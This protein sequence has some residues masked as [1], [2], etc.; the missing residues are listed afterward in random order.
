MSS[1]KKNRHNLS[2]YIPNKV[3]EQIRKDAGF[4]CVFCGCILVEYEHI[5]P[6]YHDAKEHDPTKMTL[7]CPMCH[8]KVTK[9]LLSKKRVW[10]AKKS[11]KAL[12]DGFVKDQLMV[13]TDSLELLMGNARTSMLLVAISLYGKPLFWFERCEVEES[14]RICCIFYGLDGKP[15]AYINRNEYVALIGKQDIVSKGTSLSIRDKK[16][17]TLLELSREGDKPLHIKRLF[18]QLYSQKV[19]IQGED[20]PISFGDADLPNDELGSIGNLTLAGQGGNPNG[21][22]CALGLGGSART[23]YL[24]QIYAAMQVSRFGKPIYNF[25]GSSYCWVLGD[26]IINKSYFC[27]GAISEGKVFNVAGEFVADC[28]D[29]QFLYH[30]DQYPSGE[31]IFIVQNDRTTRN[32]RKNQGYDLS[33]R[34]K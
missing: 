31:P 5:E 12:K 3:K 14:Y 24:S 8:D 16:A 20:S 30:H 28:I 4:G 1:S 29:S 18:S 13:D 10:E 33:Y 9:K 19:V 27:V 26:R 2:R 6:E 15:I 11:P 17:G 32:V 7:L 23:H 34:F 22:Q 21:M 25:D